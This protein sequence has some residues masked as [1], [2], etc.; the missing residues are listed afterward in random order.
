MNRIIFLN[1]SPRIQNS[2]SSY[3]MS[4]IKDQL[5][6]DFTLSEIHIATLTTPKAT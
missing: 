3:L 4:L 1:G 6:G 2:T 5:V